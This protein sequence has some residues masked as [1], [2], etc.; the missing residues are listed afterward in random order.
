MTI[1]RPAWLALLVLA[2]CRP[3]A[4]TDV[5][6]TDPPP[7]TWPLVEGGRYAGDTYEIVDNTCSD[8][9]QFG[10]G[11]IELTWLDADTFAWEEGDTV[12]CDVDAQ[13]ATTCTSY[14]FPLQDLPEATW[15]MTV[16]SRVLATST[17]TFTLEQPVTLSD[18]V[19]FNCDVSSYLLGMDDA[20]SFLWRGAY[21]R[22]DAVPDV[23]VAMVLTELDGVGLAGATVRMNGQTGL[24]DA[25]GRAAF[26][27]QPGTPVVFEGEAE[28]RLDVIGYLWSGATGGSLTRQV[29]SP[30]ALAA[31]G[32]ALGAAIDP[33]KGVVV[34][35]VVRR[36]SDGLMYPFT[37]VTLGLDQPY[38]LAIVADNTTDLGFV[39]GDAA[40]EGQQP[41]VQF[42]N[43][44]PGTAH[45]ELTAPEGYA[46]AAA[47][48]GPAVPDLTVAAGTLTT[49]TIL[50][51]AQ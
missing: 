50:C 18:C 29:W 16:Q 31:V 47:F 39:V 21:H 45:L 27:V 28:G 51:V 38:D 30:E 12:T 42:L 2:A 23:E 22:D 37:G 48:D 44:P 9:F 34:G 11:P 14:G 3:D 35:R 49:T 6:D 15:T 24:T 41:N 43:V 13:G 46:C 33:A 32:D 40:L 7:V 25:T 17:T 26:A 19:G 36:E 4:D 1:S 5:V 10:I 8:R 20:C